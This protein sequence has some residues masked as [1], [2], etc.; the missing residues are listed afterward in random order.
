MSYS[1]ADTRAN[2]ID[3][4]LKESWWESSMIIREYKITDGRKLLNNKRWKIKFADYLLKYKWV[5]LAIIEAKKQD[6]WMTEWLEQVKEYWKIL[7]LRFVY[8]SNWKEIYE[9][10]LQTWKGQKIEK[11]PTPEELYNKVFTQINE[12]VEKLLQEPFYMTD[13]KPRYYQEI[14]VQKTMEAIWNNKKRILLTLATWTGKT[15]IAF[16]IVWKLFQARWSLDGLWKR[17]PR[18]LFLADRNVLVDQAMNTFNPLESDI[19]KI[20]WKEI[21]KRNW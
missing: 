20:N 5:N 18:I 14:A 8:S 15:F 6:L 7:K 21:K 16:Q 4:Q 12:N 17:R 10:D 13:K 2:F 11:Y 1:E 9:F 19:L 3:V